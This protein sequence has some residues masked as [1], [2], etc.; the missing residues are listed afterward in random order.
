MMY[1]F[2]WIFMEHKKKLNIFDRNP[3]KFVFENQETQK[4]HFFI[5]KQLTNM[6]GEDIFFEPTEKTQ[7]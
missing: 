5:R 6:L 2:L 3:L 7:P 4:R 1:V